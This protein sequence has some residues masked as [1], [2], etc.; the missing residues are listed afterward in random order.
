MGPGGAYGFTPFVVEA[1]GRLGAAARNFIKLISGEDG[2][3]T[4]HLSNFYNALSAM[5]ALYNSLMLKGARRKLHTLEEEGEFFF[6]ALSG[7][8]CKLI[9]TNK[10]S[11]VLLCRIEIEQSL[12]PGK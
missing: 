12:D 5:T 3:N 9:L 2:T 4:Y 11:V 1:T 6:S 8:F 10:R 7:V